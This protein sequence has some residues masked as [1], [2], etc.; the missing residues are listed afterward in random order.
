M[1][2]YHL[3]LDQNKEL[4]QAGLAGPADRF[5]VLSCSERA[6]FGVSG[7]AY[8]NIAVAWRQSEQTRIEI[9][10]SVYDR[11]VVWVIWEHA[12]PDL[13]SEWKELE[14]RV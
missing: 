7:Q 9:F 12:F 8:N 3:A 2:Y 6:V 5:N 1:K 13:G 10:E 14:S 4:C 11:E